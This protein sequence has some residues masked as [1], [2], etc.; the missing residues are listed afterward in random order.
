MKRRNFLC[1]VAPL[2]LLSSLSSMAQSKSCPALA[3][4]VPDL[5][6]KPG[7]VW[8]YRARS[9]EPAS[10]VT[11]LQIDRS[12]KAGT[13]VHVR[14]D[15]LQ[16]H[17][18]RGELVPSIE[19]MPFTRDAMLLS[20]VD[21]VHS[22]SVLPTMEGYDRWRADC[23]GVYSISVADAVSVAEKTFNAR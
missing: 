20:I 12:A 19:H 1:L 18:P 2:L 21:L 13:I 22:V 7:Q 5:K 6:F 14:V 9:G 16:M 17:N 10:T 8:S 23:G 11:I 3:A 4:N 15:G